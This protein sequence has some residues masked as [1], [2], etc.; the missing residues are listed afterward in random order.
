MIHFPAGRI[1]SDKLEFIQAWLGK[2]RP[3]QQI[4]GS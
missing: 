3:L 1:G 2:N 4:I